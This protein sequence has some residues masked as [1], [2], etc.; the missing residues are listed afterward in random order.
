MTNG[1]TYI[2]YL[3]DT[4]LEIVEYGSDVDDLIAGPGRIGAWPVTDALANSY[5][6]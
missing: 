2:T 3:S 6:S 1:S 4:S 5:I